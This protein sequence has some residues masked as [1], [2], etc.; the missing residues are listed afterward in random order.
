M[1][2]DG[3][4]NSFYFAQIWSE[5]ADHELILA[6]LLCLDGDGSTD[7]RLYPRLMKCH[8]SHGTQEWRWSGQ[9]SPSGFDCGPQMKRIHVHTKMI[10]LI[11]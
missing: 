4:R 6:S 8:G 7:G 3:N 10:N 11:M 2:M 9:V 5:T 1:G